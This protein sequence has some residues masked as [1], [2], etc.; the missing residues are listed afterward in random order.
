MPSEQSIAP[1]DL[2]RKF[3][4]YHYYFQTS[5]QLLSSEE[6][7]WLTCS[8]NQTE[9]SVNSRLNISKCPSPTFF[10]RVV[11][12]SQISWKSIKKSSR[13]SEI[14][15]NATDG[16]NSTILPKSEQTSKMRDAD[17]IEDTR[18][19]VHDFMAF[20]LVL[21]QHPFS[22]EVIHALRVVTPMYPKVHVVVGV[23]YEFNGM[24]TQYGVSAFPQV[25]LFSK[26]FLRSKLHHQTASN[27][28]DLSV[29][30]ALWTSDFPVSY[31]NI[32]A[33]LVKRLQITNSTLSLLPSTDFFSQTFLQY[34]DALGCHAETN[35]N[36]GFCNTLVTS[37][38]SVDDLRN[39]LLKRVVLRHSLEPVVG[40]LENAI[41]YDKYGYFWVSSGCYVFLR[42]LYLL[43]L[44]FIRR[45]QAI[46]VTQQ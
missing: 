41:D 42:A 31:P 14:K 26:G 11:E 46:R 24:C 12:N 32:P 1:L 9:E 45:R 5:H 16:S 34:A 38:R 35:L 22:S 13:R 2:L 33:P 3:I 44:V 7:S 21:P 28:M 18:T 17:E 29:E 30:F 23:G 4:H 10:P 39:T 40:T 25:L 27:I 15:K 43:V 19:V 20:A 8:L 37:I 36:I 6:S